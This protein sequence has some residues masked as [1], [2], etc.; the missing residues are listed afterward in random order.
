MD[1]HKPTRPNPHR[2]HHRPVNQRQR[3][4]Y[5]TMVVSIQ[6]IYQIAEVKRKNYKK[7]HF[8][9]NIVKDAASINCIIE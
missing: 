3:A 6:F 7:C 4:D 5:S 2:R 1:L 9:T 8:I